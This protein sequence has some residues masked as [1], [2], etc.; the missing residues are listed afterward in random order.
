VLMTDMRM[1]KKKLRGVLSCGR[2]LN[3]ADWAQTVSESVSHSTIFYV[4][5]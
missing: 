4:H 1:Q 5:M 3:L 2:I